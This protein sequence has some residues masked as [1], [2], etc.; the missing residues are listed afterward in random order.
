VWKPFE[1]VSLLSFQIPCWKEAEQH[2]MLFWRQNGNINCNPEKYESNF[3]RKSL[4]LK[5]LRTSSCFEMM[6]RVFSWHLFQLHYYFIY[7]CILWIFGTPINKNT[8][9]K[10]RGMKW[11]LLF[12]RQCQKE[13]CR[14]SES[15][16]LRSWTCYFDSARKGSCCF[17]F[18]W[19]T[20]TAPVNRKSSRHRG[21]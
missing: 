21:R 5:A 6:S 17:G 13:S 19:R 16:C 18:H 2:N 11:P 10:K 14:N 1:S 7:F 15:G 20:W 4:L 8:F 9:N 12:P 3:K